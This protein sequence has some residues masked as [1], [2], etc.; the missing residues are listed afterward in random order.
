MTTIKTAKEAK[1]YVCKVCDYES[2]KLG[3]YTSHLATD[4]HARLI[5]DNEKEEKEAKIYICVC[6]SEY[7][8]NP[9][10]YKHKK[11]CTVLKEIN[12][13]DKIIDQLIIQNN[14]LLKKVEQNAED[15]KLLVED[16]IQ[17]NKQ[18]L[19]I[20]KEQKYL[21]EDQIE[22]QTQ[23][24]KQMLENAIEQK[25]IALEQKDLQR[26][27]KELQIEQKELMEQI[28]EKTGHTIINN[29]TQNTQNNTFNLNNYLTVTCKDAMNIEDMR[30]DLKKFAIT[31]EQIAF[32]ENG[33]HVLGI[34][35][36]IDSYFAS[37]P[38]IKRPV[39]CS[40]MKREIFH[41]KNKCGEWDKED[42]SGLRPHE[43]TFM[44]DINGYTF[45]K[46]IKWKDEA[47]DTN[48]SD[49]DDAKYNKVLVNMIGPL[50]NP[51][52]QVIIKGKIRAHIAKKT[53]ITKAIPLAVGSIEAVG[54]L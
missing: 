28:R 21:V 42:D 27:Q 5:K 50:S 52:K 1:K 41:W 36:I 43:K 48:N 37:I 18:M 16:Q 44:Q 33:N 32:F 51:E 7:K 22:E 25:E 54:I 46:T 24:N 13:K 10:L 9:S 12:N 6:G 20:A 47:L 17:Y 14:L 26:E 35:N 40:D 38:I 19:D 15:N 45:N 3:N 31:N 23:H 34:C 53:L 8:H 4:K 49:K 2:S 30:K 39:H 11:V 29:N